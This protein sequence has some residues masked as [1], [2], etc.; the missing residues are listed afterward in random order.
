MYIHTRPELTR[1]VS[2][3]KGAVHCRYYLLIY[4]KFP[5]ILLTYSL[6]SHHRRS[7]LITAMILIIPQ[8]PGRL[9]RRRRRPEPP[10][11][12]PDPGVLGRHDPR[13]RVALQV[14]L[15]LRQGR[16]DAVVAA[17][18]GPAPAAGGRAVVGV[19]VVGLVEADALLEPVL[20]HAVE[21]GLEVVEDDAVAEAFEDE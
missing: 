5:K 19:K 8:R 7:Y 4:V 16:L 20:A 18:D 1:N 10:L 2:F 11:P 17:Q 13:H 9:R 14:V 15:R 3:R 6:C 12:R 21:R